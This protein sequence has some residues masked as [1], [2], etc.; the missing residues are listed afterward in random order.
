MPKQEVK[1]KVTNALAA[2]ADACDVTDPVAIWVEEALA[3]TKN[4]VAGMTPTARRVLDGAMQVVV[5][6]GFGK[7]TIASISQKSGAN[8]A[9][10]KY[11][12]G[13]KAGLVSVMI[14]TVIYAELLLLQ[15]QR[16]APRGG[17]ELSQ[18]AQETIILST[19]GVPLRILFEL[20]PHALRDK[21]LRV[22]LRNYYETFYELHLGQLGAGHG[23]DTAVRSR[24]KGLAMLL[25]AV[26]D[27]LTMQA[28]VAPEHFDMVEAVRAFDVLLAHGM[29]ALVEDEVR[30]SE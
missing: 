22:Q 20:L 28:L 17:N 8:V 18:L 5:S 30:A 3:R 6:Q 2:Q 4:P 29:S 21:K 25:A 23:S 26:S 16:A 24:A 7:L 12:F 10:V 1:G 19:P 11:Y 14:D 9:A 15:K 13:N 27:G